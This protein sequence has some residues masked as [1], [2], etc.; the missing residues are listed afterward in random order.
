M[1]I[2]T[3]CAPSLPAAEDDGDF[4]L[5]S[6][7]WRSGKP[8]ASISGLYG[9]RCLQSEE[10]DRAAT[11]SGSLLLLLLPYSGQQQHEGRT[12]QWWTLS[13]VPSRKIDHYRATAR[14]PIFGTQTLHIWS[15]SGFQSKFIFIIEMIQLKTGTKSPA[16]LN[17]YWKIYSNCAC[18]PFSLDM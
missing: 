4:G 15:V 6:G 14:G 18:F 17:I 9:S 12:L 16:K 7:G 3:A 13:V 2:F 11:C 1:H 5:Q 8:A 10:L